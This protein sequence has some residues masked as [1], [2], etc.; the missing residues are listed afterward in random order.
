MNLS[1]FCQVKGE[2]ETHQRGGVGKRAASGEKGCMDRESRLRDE[3]WNQEVV[4]KAGRD[5]EG[6]KG[7]LGTVAGGRIYPTPR[8]RG[9]RT[10]TCKSL[11]SPERSGGEGVRDENMRE[12]RVREKIINSG[13]RIEELSWW[14][15]QQR[16]REREWLPTGHRREKW[17]SW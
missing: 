4:G 7:L 2:E 6:D 10:A 11:H 12:R 17:G 8:T 3:G 14:H 5:T 9:D 15:F 16:R 1:A 13:P